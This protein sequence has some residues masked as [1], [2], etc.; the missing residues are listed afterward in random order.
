MKIYILLFLSIFSL[1]SLACQGRIISSNQTFNYVQGRT[2]SINFQLQLSNS[3]SCGPLVIEVSPVRSSEF[4]FKRRQTEIPVNLS[5]DNNVSTGNGGSLLRKTILNPVDGQKPHFI[6]F[7]PNI[8]FIPRKAIYRTR[9][10][11]RV[12][13]LNNPRRNLHR[14]RVRYRLRV[15]PIF[16][17]DFSSQGSTMQFGQLS[18]G[19]TS[20][21]QMKIDGNIRYR[22]SMKSKEGGVLKNAYN[23]AT[24]GY[25]LYWK[26]KLIP[27]QKNFIQ[28]GRYPRGTQTG[29]IKAM[30]NENTKGKTDGDYL[31]II[32]VLVET[33]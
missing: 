24:I 28:I 29:E 22:L 13:P 2:Y 33:R 16:S 21:I 14:K 7:S 18:R 23:P 11:F 5:F 27:I 20:R 30:I 8:S 1:S 31:D 15:P 17:I 32:E 25:N 9:F 4:A 6:Y 12:Y 10:Q 3:S 26:N 19:K